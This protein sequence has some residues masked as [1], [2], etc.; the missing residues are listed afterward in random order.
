MI[1]YRASMGYRP[2]IEVIDVVSET[3]KTVTMELKSWGG[4]GTRR[5]AKASGFHAWFDSWDEAKNHLLNLAQREV[6][7]SR[8]RLENANSKLGNIKGMKNPESYK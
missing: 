2:E 5:E 3:E 4:N 1:K 6:E 8:V 7:L